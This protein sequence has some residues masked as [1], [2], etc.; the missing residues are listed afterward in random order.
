MCVYIIYVNTKYERRTC[1]FITNLYACA[2]QPPGKKNMNSPKDVY[3]V[4][5]YIEIYVCFDNLVPIPIFW[6]TLKGLSF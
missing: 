2:T 5:I 3:I 1:I 4:N 6:V